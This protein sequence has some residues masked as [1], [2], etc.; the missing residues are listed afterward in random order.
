MGVLNIAEMSVVPKWMYRF[1]TAAFG[2]PADCLEM[3]IRLSKNL[4]GNAKQL[5]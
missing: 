4:Y 3:E 1:N 2:I 5:E